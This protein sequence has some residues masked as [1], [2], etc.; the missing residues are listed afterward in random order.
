[1]VFKADLD[2][3]YM[4]NHQTNETACKQSCGR[5]W[6]YQILHRLVEEVLTVSWVAPSLGSLRLCQAQVKS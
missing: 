3:I 2:L 5:L 1:M 4:C 6:L